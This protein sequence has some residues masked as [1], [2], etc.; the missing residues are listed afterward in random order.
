MKIRVKKA[1]ALVLA[2]SLLITQIGCASGSIKL[3]ANNLDYP[4]S[5]SKGMFDEN[6]DVKTENRGLK[7]IDDFSFTVTRTGLFWGL[8]N[9]S[10]SKTGS[11]ED[12]SQKLNNIVK[13]KGGDGII[14]LQIKR[15]QLYSAGNA[16]LGATSTLIGSLGLIF[17]LGKQNG[18]GFAFVGLSALFPAFVQL[19]VKGKVVKYNK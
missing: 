11:T 15:N 13:E 8:F 12:I 16:F 1:L 9:F 18:P 10:F 14:D 3:K 2:M 4:V 17:F 19:K 5:M 7:V 6:L